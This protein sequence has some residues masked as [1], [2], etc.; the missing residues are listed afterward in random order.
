MEE[1]TK[2]TRS[3]LALPRIWFTI[4]FARIAQGGLVLPPITSGPVS[5]SSGGYQ[6]TR[7]IW[8]EVSGKIVSTVSTGQHFTEASCKI[9]LS[10]KSTFMT[11]V[12][13]RGGRRMTFHISRS[14]RRSGWSPWAAWRAWT[15][16]RGWTS[17]MTPRL[18]LATGGI[19]GGVAN[20][21]SPVF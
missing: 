14:W 11:L 7:V 12:R 10:Y 3:S 16:P 9:F 13:I 20:K 19:N 5:V 8:V 18:G 4:C 15:R 1:F 21:I 2:F 6:L 17:G